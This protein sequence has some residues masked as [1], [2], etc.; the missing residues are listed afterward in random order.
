METDLGSQKI[1]KEKNIKVYSKY[2]DLSENYF[3]LII[4][5]HVLEHVSNPNFFLKKIYKFLK[6]WNNFFRNFC[7]DYIYKDLIEPHIFL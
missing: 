2:E 4:F 3:D 1:L 7:L 6:K 5:S